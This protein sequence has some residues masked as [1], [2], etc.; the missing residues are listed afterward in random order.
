MSWYPLKIGIITRVGG[1]GDCRE[2]S[3][4]IHVDV[5]KF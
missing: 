3:F 2:R 4:G 1:D 5:S